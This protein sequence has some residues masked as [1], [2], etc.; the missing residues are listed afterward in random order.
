MGLQFQYPLINSS[1]NSSIFEPTIQILFSDK[2]D[3]NNDVKNNDSKA[4]ELTIS[5]LF[6]ENKY[7]GYDR[8]E[9]GCSDG[10]AD[11]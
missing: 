10:I 3:K 4:V 6:E 8:L 11:G 1:N 9:D 2:D 5:N 7:S